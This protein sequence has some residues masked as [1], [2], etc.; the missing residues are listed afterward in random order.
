MND[1]KKEF[2]ALK[3][4]AGIIMVIFLLGGLTLIFTPDD[5]FA[6]VFNRFASI[7][8]TQQ[9]MLSSPMSTIVF[10]TAGAFLLMWSFMLFKLAQNP[11][12][13]AVIATAS[14]V[15]FLILSA[16]TVSHFFSQEVT[17][18]I[19]TYIIAMRVLITAIVGL[20]FLIWTPKQ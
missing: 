4:L 12:K 20:L 7:L 11:V 9:W 8:N 2:S 15:G 3:V 14:G 18:V 16:V 19:P 6:R 1:E 10:K 5:L 13:N 17:S